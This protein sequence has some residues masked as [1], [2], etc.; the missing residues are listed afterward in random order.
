MF[1]FV[2]KVFKLFQDSPRGMLLS[3]KS[4]L[5]I[6]SVFVVEYSRA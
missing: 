3:F 6:F 4:I 5:C 2:Y 1:R